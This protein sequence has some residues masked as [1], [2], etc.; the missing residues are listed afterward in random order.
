MQ[1]ETARL[2]GPAID[3]WKHAVAA[4][5]SETLVAR[6]LTIHGS[7]LSVAGH[8]F[9]LS[10]IDRILVVGA[11][12]AG[13]GMASA[14]ESVLGPELVAEKVTGW[15]N[16]PADCV[17]PL[18][19]IVLHPAR[20]AGLNEPT[21]EGVAGALRILELVGGMTSRD[22]CLVLLSG[23]GS[24][25][26]PA[27]KAGVSL[28]D[29]QSVTRLL[30][31]RGATITEL[32]T[33]RK[34]LSR[35]KGS[36]LARMSSAGTM[37]TLVISDV[38]DDPLDVIASGPTVEDSSTP[39]DALSILKR[40]AKDD[41]A[42]VPD[43]VWHSLKTAAAND[44][45]QWR[46]DSSRMFQHVTGNN[47]VAVAA[48]ARRAEELGFCVHVLGS[49]EGG[50]ASD[51]GRE[52]AGLC[53]QIRTGRGPVQPPACVISGGE[54]V[55]RLAQTSRKRKGGRNQELALAACVRWL[56]EDVAGLV[57]VSGGT[58][59]EDGP[60]DAAGAW[61][62]AETMRTMCRKNLDPREFLAINDSYTFFE[63]A[64]GLLKTGPTHT[65]VMDVRV[66][67]VAAPEGTL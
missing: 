62:D 15:I 4:V 32:N 66:A 65:N 34:Q 19:K 2:R 35:I 3:I 11:G 58:D 8:D 24:A 6:Q 10:D 40:F 38:I 33:V 23:G 46:P 49:G 41:P 67:L 63:Q 56:E 52:L 39:A 27:P 30:M 1:D 51:I 9:E 60:T 12:K 29:K 48:A 57:L 54:P 26:L 61:V 14:V 55:V 16:V 37:I 22:L 28:S 47:A 45:P 5:S 36:G 44:A 7:T 53:L 42:V 64:G 21:E 43:P 18:K 25:L 31:S 20:P 17:R 50:V 13:A 59:G